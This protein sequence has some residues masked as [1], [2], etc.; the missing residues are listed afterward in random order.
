LKN[1][2]KIKNF[3][4]DIIDDH[5]DEHEVGG[6]IESWVARSFSHS[7]P[8]L[9]EDCPYQNYAPWWSG[10]VASKDY[11]SMPGFEDIDID[12]AFCNSLP[13]SYSET[14]DLWVEIFSNLSGRNNNNW[15]SSQEYAIQ[16]AGMAHYFNRLYFISEGWGELI[17]DTD[18]FYELFDNFA[19]VLDA[20]YIGYKIGDLISKEEVKNLFPEEFEHD[21]Y[22]FTKDAFFKIIELQNIK[23]INAILQVFINDHHVFFSFWRKLYPNFES[24]IENDF[25]EFFD[26]FMPYNGEVERYQFYRYVTEGVYE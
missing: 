2:G 7:M 26:P 4:V 12:D 23:T 5:N 18:N 24:P 17:W 6:C 8:F 16:L 3:E 14:S 9:L 10:I 22:Q 21:V 15:E 11:R 13:S 1:V 19:S 20:A 25:I